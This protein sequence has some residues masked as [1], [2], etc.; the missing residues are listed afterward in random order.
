MHVGFVGQVHQVVDHQPVVALDVEQPAA[1]GPLI[2]VGPFQVMDQRRV[3]QGLVAGPDPDE[4]VALHRGEGLVAGEAAHP[5]AGHFHGLAVAAHHQAVIT[6]YQVAV[7]DIAQ[8]QRRAAMGAE[9]L[10][11]GYPTFMGA[12][13][14]HVFAADLPAQGLALQFIGGAGNVPGI[15]G[16]HDVSPGVCCFYLMDPLNGWRSGGVKQIC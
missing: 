4:T 3:G 6:A 13:E 8:G 16:V 14:H 5:L 2:V 15:L 9:I 12:V 11:G 7:L 1:I 10:D